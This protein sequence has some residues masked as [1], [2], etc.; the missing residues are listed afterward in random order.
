MDAS[1]ATSRNSLHMT[2]L[3]QNPPQLPATKA[4]H[5][6]AGAVHRALATG[7]SQLCVRGYA[8]PQ[9]GTISNKARTA[10][11]GKYLLWIIGSASVC[12]MPAQRLNF[13]AL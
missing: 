8:L 9:V 5:S 4:R 12:G 11:C 7:R 2:G 13:K 1:Q 6:E 3:R 10:D